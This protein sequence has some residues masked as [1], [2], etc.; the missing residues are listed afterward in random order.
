MMGPKG[1]GYSE[2]CMLMEKIKTKEKTRIKHVRS[3]E[4]DCE[5]GVRRMNRSYDTDCERCKGVKIKKTTRYESE[6]CI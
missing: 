1:E 3:V 6:D 4:H 5:N 2:G